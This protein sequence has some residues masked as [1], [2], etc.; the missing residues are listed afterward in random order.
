PGLEVGGAGS[1]RLEGQPCRAH[2]VGVAY[3]G[4]LEDPHPEVVGAAEVVEL[5]VERA[6][7]DE[8]TGE[9]HGPGAVAIHSARGDVATVA[10]EGRHEHTGGLVAGL[11]HRVIERALLGVDDPVGGGGLCAG[12]RPLGFPGLHRDVGVAAGG[13]RVAFAAGLAG[14]LRIEAGAVHVLVV[15][16]TDRLSA[17]ALPVPDVREFAWGA[18][19][20]VPVGLARL[21][22]VAGGEAAAL[23]EVL[24][25]HVPDHGHLVFVVQVAVAPLVVRVGQ[26]LPGAVRLLLEGCA[27]QALRGVGPGHQE[28]DRIPAVERLQADGSPPVGQVGPAGNGNDDLAGL[29]PDR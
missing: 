4:V 21:A 12:S 11:V 23:R 19:L 22:G 20:L 16:L 14:G 7:G 3:L 28:V 27:A 1:L 26:L 8:L 13:A 10:G 5:H 29:A 18:G 15:D 25:A 9:F 17:H 24:N 6:P 2:L